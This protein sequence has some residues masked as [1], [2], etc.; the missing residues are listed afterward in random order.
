MKNRIIL[1]AAAI[2]AMAVSCQKEDTQAVIKT[3][4]MTISAGVNTKT[5]LDGTK[6]V[7]SAD[8]AISVFDVAG[9]NNCFEQKQEPPKGSSA[10]F[11]G[12]VS[13]GTESFYAVYPYNESNNIVGD[14]IHVTLLSKQTPK[15]GSFAEEHNISVAKGIRNRG[16]NT[17]VTGVVFKNVCALLKFTVPT[18][19][20][21][22]TSVVVSSDT[23]LAGE[24][25]ID[26]SKDT[27]SVS[28]SG[29]KTVS[30]EKSAN[31]P[32]DNNSTFWFVV[33]P[34]TLNGLTITVKTANNNTYVMSTNKEIA[35]TAGKSTNI[36][37]LKLGTTAYA[38]HTYENEVL[39]GTS[40]TV[41]NIDTSK[42]SIK[43]YTIKNSVGTVV[44]NSDDASIEESWPYLP[45]GTYTVTGK[46]E[47]GNTIDPVMFEVLAPEFTVTTPDAYTTYDMAYNNKGG[48]EKA[49]KSNAETI[50]NL[51]SAPSV[52]ISNKIL[53]NQNYNTIK[54]SF[55]TKVDETIIAA[56]TETM[57]GLEWGE[58]IVST[59]YTFDGAIG[60]GSKTVNITGLPYNVKPPKKVGEHPWDSN[61]YIN[62]D[63]NLLSS[64]GWESNYVAIKSTIR[65]LDITS[66]RFSITESTKVKVSV[67]AELRS[68]G[69]LYVYVAANLRC[70]IADGSVFISRDYKG[71]GLG[72]T[73]A[74]RKTDEGTNTLTTNANYLRIFQPSGAT[75]PEVRVYEVKIEYN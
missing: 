55:V 31:E 1:M 66:P 62:N 7:W 54:G 40:V 59:S 56:S 71:S 73:K 13:K 6:V 65:D 10:R 9:I 8:D 11:E 36:G 33:A 15:V 30:M 26:Y 51:N 16:E 50:Y 74:D 39:T 20:T 38:E 14:K 28:V 48:I 43:S 24:M 49:N 25:E 53:S 21:N 41:T 68:T 52:S 29:Q 5:S 19:V 23:D 27:P 47:D 72:G 35:L 57:E 61:A 17:E 32:F 67:D 46:Y 42:P 60:S 34:T 12:A 44:R 18:Y 37:V 69:A 45:Q 22:V 64:I 3:E 4:P 63:T 2:A 75:G 58:H 70:S